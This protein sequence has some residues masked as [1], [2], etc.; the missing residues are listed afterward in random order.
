MHGIAILVCVYRRAPNQP[1]PSS[2]ASTVFALSADFVP[3][4]VGELHADDNA[5][6]SPTPTERRINRERRM[7]FGV[8]ATGKAAHTFAGWLLNAI[9]GKKGA[10][11][12]TT[13]HGYQA[14]EVGTP[15]VH[16]VSPGVQ[17]E[18]EGITRPGDL[19]R[20]HKIFT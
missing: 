2:F 20:R 4:V 17:D 18:T 9:L 15:V 3:G 19:L 7:I 1:W 16:H 8:A 12:A 13:C 6:I 11:S 10:G 5:T 14:S